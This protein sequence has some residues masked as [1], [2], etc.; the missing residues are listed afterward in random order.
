MP[1]DAQF[2]SFL[3]KI[4][5]AATGLDLKLSAT[6]LA[7]KMSM[8]LCDQFATQLCRGGITR[9]AV[10]TTA[11]GV[12]IPFNLNDVNKLTSI[13]QGF[14]MDSKLFAYLA[15]LNAKTLNTLRLAFESENNWR[16]A[17]YGKNANSRTPTIYTSLTIFA[18][19]VGLTFH[20][21][22]W[23]KVEG[24]A[25]F[26][27]LDRLVVGDIYPFSDDVLFRDNGRT[28]KQLGL[29]YCVIAGR[30]LD[31][32]SVFGR[33]G[34][35]RM[36]T[37]DIY[38]CKRCSPLRHAETPPYVNQQLCSAMG[39]TAKLTL[40]GGA[41]C[42]SFV[43]AIEVA[44]VIDTLRSLALCD[45]ALNLPKILRVLSVFRGLVTLVCNIADSPS[46]NF[47]GRM[48]EELPS[49]LGAKHFPLSR[50]FKRLNIL[51]KENRGSGDDGDEF[52]FNRAVDIDNVAKTTAYAAMKLAAICPNF[53]HVD[54]PKKFRAV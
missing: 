54:L 34:V 51:A 42:M 19:E 26:P 21:V 7:N 44:P 16:I 5:P 48:A 11:A 6:S 32:F 47:T 49:A 14:G 24:A 23:S 31:L 12:P 30:N 41:T 2:A 13:T 3:R 50:N 35:P 43:N 37:I 1:S 17:I 8:R 29:P 46:L 27:A 45:F 22:V 38:K 39:A 25:P 9:V 4:A 52:E 53:A 20:D 18:L 40:V 10:E 36:D 33:N 28:L 15:H